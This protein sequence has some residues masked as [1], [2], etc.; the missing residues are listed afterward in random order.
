M[1]ELRQDP[2]TRDWV[3]INQERAQRP[4]DGA[5]PQDI[6]TCPFCPGNESLTPAAVD[7]LEV[8]GDWSVRAVPNRFPVARAEAPRRS[9]G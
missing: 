6:R 1:P 8:A 5:A 2:I 4:Q 7:S 9:P 3:I